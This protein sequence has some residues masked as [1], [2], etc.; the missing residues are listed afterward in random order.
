MVILIYG[1]VVILIGILMGKLI[2]V[3]AKIDED[4]KRKVDELG[5]SI[6]ALVR[7]ALED[8]IKA[9]ELQRIL[10]ALKGEVEGAPE[11]P[12]GTVVKIIRNM[13]EGL[14]PV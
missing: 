10:E 12:E 4:L 11:L 1:F 9:R 8:E 2:T 13:R 7:R 3:S 14:P 5:M 6:S